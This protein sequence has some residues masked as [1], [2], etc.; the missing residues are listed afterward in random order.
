MYDPNHMFSREVY[1]LIKVGN[2]KSIYDKITTHAF[3]K[4]ETAIEFVRCAVAQDKENG[5]LGALMKKKGLLHTVF[6]ALSVAQHNMEVKTPD[7]FTRGNVD[8]S[9]CAIFFYC[10]KIIKHQNKKK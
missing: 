9:S 3:W 5:K 7:Y 8:N 6:I 10:I 4:Q 1:E 2:I